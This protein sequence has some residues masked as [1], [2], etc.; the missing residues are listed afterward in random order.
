MSA[1]DAPGVR[2]LEDHITRRAAVA[3]VDVAGP[4]AS[5]LADYIALLA[6]WN[7]KINLTALPLEPPTDAAID[8]L[9]VEALVAARHVRSTDRRAIDIGSGGGSPAIPLNLARPELRF[10]LVEIKSR[11]SAFLR[12]AGRE[13]GLESL[14]VETARVEDVSSQGHLAGAFDLVTVRAVRVDEALLRSV[15]LLLR[16]SGQLF[17]FGGAKIFE[18]LPGSDRTGW[19]VTGTEA[20]GELLIVAIN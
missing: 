16:P 8:R 10:T 9:I 17:W 12:E 13:L 20:I 7:R 4:L 6:K 1:S 14:G 11:K 19:T 18:G 5:R 2:E 15:G 3:G